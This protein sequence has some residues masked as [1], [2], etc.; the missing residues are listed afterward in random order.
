MKRSLLLLFLAISLFS[1]Q[2][3]SSVTEN[4]CCTRIR[5]LHFSP[6]TPTVSVSANYFNIQEL[7]V[8]SLAY[9]GI[10]P[11]SGYLPIDAPIEPDAQGWSKFKLLAKD[12]ITGQT[13]APVNPN[14]S[15]QKGI[16]YTVALADTGLGGFWLS[17]PDR[18]PPVG[19]ADTVTAYVRLVNLSA[20]PRLNLKLDEEL[21]DATPK[22]AT[23]PWLRIRAKRYRL[24][25]VEE[26]QI[27]IWRS[28][29]TQTIESGKVYQVYYNADTVRILSD[30]FQGL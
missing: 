9:V 27:E 28:E 5:I 23:S 24:S 19:A 18:A 21:T 3:D 4:H 15:W 17:I 26:G 8:D 30:R 13:A 25:I 6:Y 2:K 14:F 10:F 1:C 11:Q 12:L 29:Q 20:N 16:P 7:L 22:L